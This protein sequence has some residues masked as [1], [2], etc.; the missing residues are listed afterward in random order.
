[1]SSFNIKTYPFLKNYK[2]KTDALKQVVIRARIYYQE[3]G[4]QKFQQT[5]DIP[6][7]DDE[8]QIIR[9]TEAEFLNRQTSENLKYRLPEVE[10]L[11]RKAIYR[12]TRENLFL[13]IK[14]IHKYTYELH[15][16]SD[17][18]LTTM[19]FNEDV[20]KIFG[21]PVPIGV[22]ESFI[23]EKHT[24]EVTGELVLFEELEDIAKNI[25]GE[26]YEVRRKGETEKLDFNTRYKSGEF[27]RDNIFECFGFCWSNHPT[28]NEPL[29]ADSYKGLLLRLY[30][31]RYNANPP[32]HVK[33]FNE[34][35]VVEFLKF[36]VS[37]GFAVVHPKNY[38]PFNLPKLKLALIKAERQP[39]K[40]G[41]FEKLVK[42]LKR[43]IFLL[44]KYK[45]V[46]Y[47][48]DVKFIDAIDF[49]GRD[50]N[51]TS[52]TR[53]G[54]SLTIE[55][56]DRLCKANFEDTTLNIAR[57]MFI[58]ATMG[59][60]LRG[61]EFFNDELSVQNL[62]GKLALHIYRSKTQTIEINPVFGILEEVIKS[63]HNQLPEFLS[64]IDLR[65]ALKEIASILNFDRIIFSPNTY[66]DS[67]GGQIKHVLKDIFSIYFARKTFV[68]FLDSS[69]MSDDDI[70]EFTSHSK[71]ETLK[72]YKGNL[73]LTN[74]FKLLEKLQLQT[75]FQ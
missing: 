68:E 8:G 18:H 67:K 16:E 54:H 10:L 45:I 7:F 71:R 27:D 70:I 46:N 62:D 73:S 32:E 6:L 29:I 36:I 38:T 60:G 49:V 40:F 72:H 21:Y 63:N 59:G 3:N 26:F 51:K 12:I 39:Y 31:Y 65:K 5:F 15:Q 50:V 43:Y 69:G 1:M 64:D 25:E 55:E 57:N 14:N 56:F 44:Q 74:K 52:Y 24:N 28:K 66:I 19:T 2:R 13:D 48:S 58:I 22:W 47:S 20:E 34:E 23:S 33:Y 37:E 75:A 42:H 4:K 53:R 11:I 41:A 17:K 9:V 35:W 61:E 30:D